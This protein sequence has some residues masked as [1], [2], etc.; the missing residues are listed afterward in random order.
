VLEVTRKVA[1]RH[2]LADR[3]TLAPGDFATA[4]FGSGHHVATI[5]HILHSEGVERSKAL[6][7]KTFDALA[8]GGTVAI[9]EF[10]LNDDRQGPPPSLIFAINMLVNTDEGDAFSFAEISAWLLEVGFLNP[11]LLPG[12]GVSPLVLATKPG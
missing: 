1:N 5:G 11:R 3:L 9:M 12:P 6:L 8:P 2:G 4:D 10:L 7:K